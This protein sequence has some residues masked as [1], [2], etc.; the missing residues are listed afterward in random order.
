MQKPSNFGREL[1]NRGGMK[2]S[3]TRATF[4]GRKDY[5]RSPKPAAPS[6]GLGGLMPRVRK[7]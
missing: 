3:K 5:V 6:S 1:A 2:D 7:P 4:A